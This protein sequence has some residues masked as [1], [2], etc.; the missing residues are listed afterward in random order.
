MTG[1]ARVSDHLR[2]SSLAKLAR[3]FESDRTLRRCSA[4]L[5]GDLRSGARQTVHPSCPR[6]SGDHEG[7]NSGPHPSIASNTEAMA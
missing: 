1:A 2:M 4:P 6:L 5:H 3:P 7:A